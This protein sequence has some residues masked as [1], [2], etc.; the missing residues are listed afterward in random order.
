MTDKSESGLSRRDLLKLGSAA[1]AATLAGCPGL[2]LG[3]EQGTETPQSDET[4]SGGEQT[5]PDEGTEREQSIPHADS[6]ETVVNMVA[7]AGADP[8]G[9]E[10]IVPILANQ[11]GNDTLLYFPEGRYLMDGMWTL[12]EFTNLGIVGDGATIVPRNGYTGYLFVLGYAHKSATDLLVE[13]LEFDFTADETNPR[14]LQAQ[15]ED[16]LVVRDVAASGTSGTAR[17]DVTTEGGSGVVERLRLPDGGRDPNRVGVLVGPENVG[18]ITFRKCHVEG[19]PGNGLYASPSNGPIHVEGGFYA[20]NAIASVRVSSPATVRDV[21]VRCDRAPENFENMRGIRLRN[22]DSVLVENCT[23]EM[24]DV[25]YSEGAIV[26]GRMMESAT[27]R[28]IDITL[29]ADEVP[30]IHAKSPTN[31][32]HAAIEC[33]DISV[34]G[35]AAKGSTVEIVDRDDCVLDNVSIEQTG[36]DRDGIHMIRSTESVLRSSA[37]DVTGR[38]LVLEQSKLQRVNNSL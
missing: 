20:N 18:E 25:T 3:D 24:M 2:D 35:E 19:F 27:I 23:V 13:G 32:E 8:E 31:T 5:T 4:P 11:A 6:Y 16:N 17:F 1:G 12:R 37:I 15:V 28:N 34:S 22:G 33:R 30:A 38:P 7:D 21:H 9:N 26:I 14:P 29:S 10:S 36:D